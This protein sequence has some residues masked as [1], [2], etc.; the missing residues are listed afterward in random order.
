MTVEKEQLEDTVIKLFNALDKRLG[1]LINNA[2]KQRQYEM[3]NNLVV[4]QQELEDL[5]DITIAYG[6]SGDPT[7]PWEEMKRRLEK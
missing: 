6:R 7:I 5:H 1:Q 2:T 3:A 4:V